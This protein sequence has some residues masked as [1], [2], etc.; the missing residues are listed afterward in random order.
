M[1][2]LGKLSVFCGQRTEDLLLSKAPMLE[3]YFAI[4]MSAG[5]NDKLLLRALPRVIDG[6]CPQM[7]LLPD[8]LLRLAW[9]VRGCTPAVGAEPSCFYH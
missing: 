2:L 1:D 9:E 7:D 5:D 8:F 6:H 4:S 3:E